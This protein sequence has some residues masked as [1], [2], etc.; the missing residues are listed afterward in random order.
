MAKWNAPRELKNW[1]IHYCDN[2]PKALGYACGIEDMARC[3]I[4]ICAI[5]ESL[6]EDM[7]KFAHSIGLEFVD[8][9]VTKIP[10]GVLYEVS[11]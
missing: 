9:P 4:I 2:C 5:A 6:R 11:D 10:E 7:V 1:Y 3:E 8:S